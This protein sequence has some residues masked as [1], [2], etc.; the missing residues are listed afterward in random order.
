[1]QVLKLFIKLYILTTLTLVHEFY[2]EGP[3]YTKIHL[4]FVTRLK[5]T[6]ILAGTWSAGF[7]LGEMEGSGKPSLKLW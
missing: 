6:L 3:T 4:D 5:N 2:V 1:M 7:S